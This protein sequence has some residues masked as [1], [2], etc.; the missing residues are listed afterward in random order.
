[1]G[2]IPGPFGDPASNTFP[3]QSRLSE[4]PPGPVIA[5]TPSAATGHVLQEPRLMAIARDG[6]TTP[7][8]TKFSDPELPIIAQMAMCP[9][10]GQDITYSS[11]SR[12]V[13]PGYSVGQ[14]VDHL[15]SEMLTLLRFFASYDKT[16]VTKKLFSRFLGRQTSVTY[17][18]D[19]DLTAKFE[20]HENIKSFC[21]RALRHPQSSPHPLAPVVPDR[22]HDAL[23]ESNWNIHEASILTDL[24]APAV[25]LKHK[26]FGIGIP[27]T[28]DW[29]NGLAIMVN[30]IQ[31]VY[32]LATAYF[33]DT[34]RNQYSITLQYRFYDVF[35]LDDDDLREFG[36]KTAGPI[37]T[38]GVGITA[39]WQLQHQFGF[40]PLVTRVVL[41]KTFTQPMV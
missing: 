32:I 5:K 6:V 18:D 37:G 7:K 4:V 30:G 13:S 26:F 27:I 29:D 41:N 36:A 12:T 16:G 19:P 14:N 25:N 17:F 34:A 1:M 3:P 8:P 15:K 22:I 11:S 10:Y 40:A 20:E 33:V 24:G 31:H 9:R 23:R 28:K 38:P 35:G 21:E 39:W 2:R